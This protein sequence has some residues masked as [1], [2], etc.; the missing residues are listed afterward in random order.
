MNFELLARSTSEKNVQAAFIKTNSY[1]KILLLQNP[2]HPKSAKTL[3]IK[4]E[5]DTSPPFGSAYETRYL[6]FPF[7]FP[8]T[9]QDSASLFAG[10]IHALLC[11]P[12]VKGRD[13]YDFIWY[14]A[15]KT[16]VNLPFVSS[17]I[18]QHGPWKGLD[19]NFD[20]TWLLKELHKK[21]ASI[22][23]EMAKSDVE[24]FLPASKLP[25][26]QVWSQAFFD[27]R[28]EK[29]ASGFI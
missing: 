17:S 22:D 27:S 12:Y 19:I 1:G 23:W 8:V 24:R 10:K 4:I 11:R 15:R 6:D 21:V 29:V 18:F 25:S 9:L 20:L 14:V 3:S 16:P 5:L 13:W 26:L 28:I 2:I 7:A